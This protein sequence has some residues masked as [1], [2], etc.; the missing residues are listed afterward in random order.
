MENIVNSIIHD[1]TPKKHIKNNP[2]IRHRQTPHLKVQ[3]QQYIITKF[4]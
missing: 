4:Q 2:K 3:T 1:P